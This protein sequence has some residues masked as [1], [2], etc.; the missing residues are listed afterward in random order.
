[1]SYEQWH[2]P[3][4]LNLSI[5]DIL[6]SM[7]LSWADSPVHNNPGSLCLPSA[8]WQLLPEKSLQGLRVTGG[9]LG[10]PLS[11]PTAIQAPGSHDMK[12]EDRHNKANECNFLGSSFNEQREEKLL[13]ARYL[14]LPTNES[15]RSKGQAAGWGCSS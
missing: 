5:T 15:V 1:M 7:I 8:A 11:P 13:S 3:G 12:G 6:D 10:S 4:I 9:P 2:K 14:P